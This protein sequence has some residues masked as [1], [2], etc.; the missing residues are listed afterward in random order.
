MK[1]LMVCL[2]NI[3]RSPLAEGILAAKL[4]EGYQV[5]SCGTI[6]MH[7]GEN[8]D[9]RAV[10]AATH[11][12]VDISKQ[13]SRP[14]TDA[15]FDEYDRILCMDKSVYE[16]VMAKAKTEEQK[17]KIALFLEEAGVENHRTEVPDPY[18][19]EMADF[20]EVYKLIDGACTKIA[21]KIQT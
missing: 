20:H 12:G 4:P 9:H 17:Q 2:G 13:K 21:E 11:Y 10:K 7:E 1:I 15:D 5:D 6:S 8:P 18:W 3:C 19:G 16:D 14:I